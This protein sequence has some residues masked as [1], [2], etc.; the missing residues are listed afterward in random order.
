MVRFE[1]EAV[2]EDLNNAQAL[3]PLREQ[4]VVIEQMLSDSH[5]AWTG[6][7]VESCLAAY[8][9]A[10]VAAKDQGDLGAAL[11]PLAGVLASRRERK[12]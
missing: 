12:G 3:Q 11:E 7:A 2:L 1:G 8:R 9:V 6:E 5:L 10:K 4:L